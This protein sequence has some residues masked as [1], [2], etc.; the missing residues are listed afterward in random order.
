MIL[1]IVTVVLSKVN[2]IN[3]ICLAF[4]AGFILWI[5]AT[6][7]KKANA[8]LTIFNW[9]P[10]EIINPQAYKPQLGEGIVFKKDYFNFVLFFIENE[11]KISGGQV[12]NDYLDNIPYYGK[13]YS[14]DGILLHNKIQIMKLWGKL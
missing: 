5:S 6:Y 2:A 3:Y 11:L 10:Q 7:L 13:V 9:N 4:L 14:L 12:I 8:E 1:V